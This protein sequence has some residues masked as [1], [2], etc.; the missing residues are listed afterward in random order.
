MKYSQKI[1]ALA[2]LIASACMLTACSNGTASQ[3]SSES[4]SSQTAAST[5][6]QAT[7]S[8]AEQTPSQTAEQTSSE[9]SAPDENDVLPITLLAPGGYAVKPSDIASVFGEDGQ[10]SPEQL[11]EDNWFSM[12]CN[13]FCYAAE[14]TGFNLNCFEDDI[15]LDTE[16][17]AFGENSYER[18]EVGDT[19]SGFTVTQANSSFSQSAGFVGGQIKLEEAVKL[20]GW[21]RLA[22]ADDVYTMKGDVEFIVD[23]DSMTLPVVN[24][25]MTE[26]GE[27]VSNLW[28]QATESAVWV[29]EY[30]EFDIGNINDETTD[31]DLSMLYDDGTYTR[32]RITLDDITLSS[33]IDFVSYITAHIVDIDAI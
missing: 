23:G 28:K 3:S 20:T 11:T 33:M 7:A 22:P 29:N 25:S 16:I 2:A 13:T 6:E 5:A 30:P 15:T 26:D 12:E 32:V 31:A 24:F 14:P 19:I 27:L 21:A 10:I 18:V 8:A 9:S 1:A 17:P 4:A